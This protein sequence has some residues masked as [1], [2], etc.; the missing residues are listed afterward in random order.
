MKSGREVR[1]GKGGGEGFGMKIIS[2]QAKGASANVKI[3]N[4]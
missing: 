4:P 2:I 1:L 3:D